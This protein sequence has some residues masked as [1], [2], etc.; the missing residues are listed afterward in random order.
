MVFLMTLRRM[1]LNITAHGFRSTFRDWASEQTNYP[2]AVME[3]A[4]AHTLKDKTEAAYSR[5][6]L[7]DKR[8]ALMNDWSKFCQTPVKTKSKQKAV[9]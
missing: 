3:A 2:H 4:L 7:F 6:D 1:K 5:T 9:G 8:R